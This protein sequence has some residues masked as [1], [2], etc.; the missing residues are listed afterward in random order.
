MD[1]AP[2]VFDHEVLLSEVGWVRRLARSLVADAHL[3]DDLAQDACLAAL[4][5]SPRTDRPIRGWLATV[6]RNLVR[7]SKRRD[8]RRRAREERAARPEA[9]DA[10]ADLVERVALQREVVDAVLAL[11][12][13]CRTAVLLRFF[14]G[15]PPRR[16]AERTGVPV[17]TAKTRLARGL[18]RLRNAL[19]AARGGD[20]Q[21]W[22]V[23]LLPLAKPPAGA[24]TPLLGGL[25]MATKTK[26]AIAAILLAA[27]S[28][29][30]W[31]V[32]SPVPAAGD[33]P[34]AGTAVAASPPAVDRGA[35]GI[36]GPRS[37]A[38]LR[39]GA[40]GTTP[41]PASAPQPPADP[42]LH[43]RVFDTEARPAAGVEIDFLPRGVSPA[44]GARP[45]AASA[46]D[47]TF[48]TEPPDTAGRFVGTG[49]GFVTVL[50]AD[51]EP[52]ASRHDP[53][54][55]VA[56]PL[57]LGGRV[58]DER[59]DPV[60]GARVAVKLPA[61]FRARF[62]EVLDACVEAASDA[63]SGEEGRFEL[64]RAP[65][66]RD[67]VLLATREGFEDA[68]IPLPASSEASIEIVL[69][70]PYL[71]RESV[72]GQVVDSRGSPVPDAWVSAGAEAA[73]T[74]PGGAFVLDLHETPNA[75]SL[76]AL[77]EGLSP[78][79]YVAPL[80]PQ[81]GLPSWPDSVV[82]RLGDPPLSIG[83]RVR[84]A[85]GTPVS[86]AQVWVEDP[87]S[88][89]SVEGGL[90]HVET[91]LRG[92]PEAWSVLADAEG[93][94]R[95]GGL[96][97]RSYALAA[98]DPASLVLARAPTVPAGTEGVELVVPENAL[99]E[100]V[101]GQVVSRTG[102]PVAGVRLEV[103]RVLFR[104]PGPG[105]R[106]EEEGFRGV[107]R[108][109]S[110]GGT[111]SDPEGRFELSRVPRTG[112][113]LVLGGDAVLPKQVPIPDPLP[114]EGMRIVASLRFH[115]RVELRDARPGD[116]IAVEDDA[117]HE[118]RLE[119]FMGG[120][121]RITRIRAELVDGS[122][123]VLAVSD[124]ARVLVVYRGTEV[125]RRLSLDLAP[126]E[127]NVVRP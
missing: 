97:D 7:Q 17:A 119:L 123:A 6:V 25:L 56:S 27:L 88:F 40:A 120:S 82:L 92:G 8:A 63:Q 86:N 75:A 13:P 32:R 50:A 70:R 77:K 111:T 34:P 46:V 23:A 19:D 72:H 31:V 73:R 114:P 110:S 28:G 85:D 21:A 104:V 64:P 124:A 18:A 30:F 49:P 79:F 42:R 127:L 37:P 54:V 4:E 59:G 113:R 20:R 15:L 80:H 112:A 125:L 93:R 45:R 99:H 68:R 24:A 98:L 52:G 62:P 2:R 84:R 117:G 90:A 121:S 69:R 43:G 22:L 57:S 96:L 41:E 76:T 118:Q 74:D 58:V 81:T 14:E 95:L 126:G 10:G 115:L 36:P 29:V 3:A 78:A 122:S 66:V 61:G 87:R 33:A 67:G 16:V 89:G 12:E 48:E 55:V 44:S 39:M 26:V 109:A 108:A 91:L 116:E 11:E 103:S 47:G 102:R 65:G 51:H 38:P 94:F 60:P 100:R 9:S 107:T 1:R 35:A 83:G 5:A 106:G 101:R 105:S 71:G 53:V